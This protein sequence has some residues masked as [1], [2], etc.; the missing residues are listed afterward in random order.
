MSSPVGHSLTGM[1]LY[2]SYN[3]WGSLWSHRNE[4]LLYIFFAVAADLD[5]IPGLI[6]GDIYRYH[7][8]PLHSI[9]FALLFTLP[10]SLPRLKRGPK[11]FLSSWGIFFS[12]YC[13]HLFVD[14]FTIDRRFPY[15]SP[16]LW[17][18]W[19]RYISSPFT[20]LPPVY[21]ESWAALISLNNLH[22]ML[23]EVAIFLPLL[24]LIYWYRKSKGEKSQSTEHHDK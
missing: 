22:T 8:G 12:L 13:T 4:I 24:L 7:H 9:F 11:R 2:L 10:F 20:F 5:F 19:D 23:I 18:I 16:L 15:G 3:K 6:A 1:I 17:P 21:K 14:F